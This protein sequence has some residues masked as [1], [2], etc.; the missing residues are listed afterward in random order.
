MH[1]DHVKVALMGSWIVAI[2]AL[3]Y[4]AGVTSFAAWAALTVISLAPPAVMARLW[5]KPA[6]SMSESIQDALR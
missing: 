1:T 4:L 6:P 3:G 2:G 5:N